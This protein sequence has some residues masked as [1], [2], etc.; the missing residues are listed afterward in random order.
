MTSAIYDKSMFQE[1]SY[2]EM[3]GVDGGMDLHQAAQLVIDITGVAFTPAALIAAAGPWAVLAA[4]F[5]GT[6]A[7]HS[8]ITTLR[9]Y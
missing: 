8:L 2:D 4:A 9:N 5:G 1:L 7:M 3:M 6:A